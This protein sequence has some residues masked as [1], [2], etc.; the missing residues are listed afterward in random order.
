MH[1]KLGPFFSQQS[2]SFRQS[3]KTVS[4]VPCSGFLFRHKLLHKHRLLENLL[5]NLVNHLVNPHLDFFLLR[6]RIRKSFSLSPFPKEF[7]LAPHPP[8]VPFVH[9]SFP[10][11]NQLRTDIALLR[12]VILVEG[13]AVFLQVFAYLALLVLGE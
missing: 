2:F 7:R 6:F 12:S 13:P 5:L 10:E 1:T 3:R 11:G 8:R 9:Q 4:K